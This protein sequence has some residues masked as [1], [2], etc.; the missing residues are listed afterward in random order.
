MSMFSIFN[1]S[2]S[3]ISAQSQRL[4]VVASNLA[5]VDAVAGPDGQAYKARQVL[6]QSNAVPMDVRTRAAAKL[7]EF[8][9]LPLDTVFFVNSGSEAND[10]VVR[11]VWYMNNALG[12]PKKKKFVS[13]QKAFHG[14][15]MMSGSLTGLPHLH[16]DF[17]LPLYLVV[18]HPGGDATRLDPVRERRSAPP[19]GSWPPA[20]AGHRGLPRAGSSRS[21]RRWS[22]NRSPSTPSRPRCGT[23]CSASRPSPPPVS[24]TVC[25]PGCPVI[26]IRRLGVAPACW[27]RVARRPA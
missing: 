3:A 26:A 11:I 6:F 23:G 9:A 27:F 12:R 13:R 14:S 21:G 8:A 25:G 16:R 4:N 5:N 22:G 24:V 1:V 20:G 10:S 2:G 15:T 18:K 7:V 17:D 19:R